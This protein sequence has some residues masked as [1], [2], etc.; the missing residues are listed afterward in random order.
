[1]DIY[2]DSFSSTNYILIFKIYHNEPFFPFSE[3]RP[4]CR[5]IFISYVLYYLY[6]KAVRRKYELPHQSTK[7]TVQ[8]KGAKFKQE[9]CNCQC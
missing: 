7:F 5:L 4:M 2:A 8:P 3:G 9:L 1:M 6:R